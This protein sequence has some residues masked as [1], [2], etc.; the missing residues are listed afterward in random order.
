MKNLSKLKLNSLS[1]NEIRKAE[2]KLVVGGDGYVLPEWVITY[3]P[4][5][6]LYAG[7]QEGPNDAYYGGASKTEN[8]N[9]NN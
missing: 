1:Q 5:P 9:A 6:C 3:V 8:R 7:A 2:Q 4:C